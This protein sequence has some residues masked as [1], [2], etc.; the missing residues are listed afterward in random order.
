MHRIAEIKHNEGW[1]TMAAYVSS[2][3]FGVA[4]HIDCSN[5]SEHKLHHNSVWL[6]LRHHPLRVRGHGGPI[7]AIS[8]NPG[9]TDGKIAG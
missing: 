9:S 7:P 8:L 2:C 3:L 4:G 1:K 5:E 6:T